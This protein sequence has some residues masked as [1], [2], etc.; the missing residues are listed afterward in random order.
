MVVTRKAI[1][2]SGEADIIDELV[3]MLEMNEAQSGEHLF[4]IKEV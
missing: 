1:M 4:D 2:I 3:E